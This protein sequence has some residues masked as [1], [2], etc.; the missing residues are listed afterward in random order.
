MKI[1]SKNLNSQKEGVG[2]RVGGRVETWLL[3]AGFPT[4]TVR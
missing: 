3:T 4:L 2:V 1:I